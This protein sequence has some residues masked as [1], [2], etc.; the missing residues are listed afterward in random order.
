MAAS[1]RKADWLHLQQQHALTSRGWFFRP[2]VL[3]MC[4][5]SRLLCVLA[6]YLC[7]LHREGRISPATP[8]NPGVPCVLCSLAVPGVLSFLCVT[9]RNQNN[10]NPAE[11]NGKKQ[12]KHHQTPMH[13]YTL[14]K[15]TIILHVCVADWGAGPVQRWPHVSCKF[16]WASCSMYLCSMGTYLPTTRVLA[17]VMVFS[18]VIRA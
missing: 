7:V 11:D 2:L 15:H 4:C 1:T 3:Y 9:P 8:R 5:V 14:V 16:V 10:I 18:C 6:A 13:T 17:I 12:Y